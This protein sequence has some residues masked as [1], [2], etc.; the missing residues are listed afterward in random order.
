MRPALNFDP[1][2]LLRAQGVQVA[3]LD[4]DAIHTHLT[5]CTEA[6]IQSG[7]HAIGDGAVGAS[8]AAGSR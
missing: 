8:A 7:F 4:V 3:F 2:L 6:G 5:A 1:E